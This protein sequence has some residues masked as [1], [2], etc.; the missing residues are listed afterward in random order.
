[1]LLWQV[2]THFCDIFLGYQRQHTIKSTH[3]VHATSRVS[4]GLLSDTKSI[5]RTSQVNY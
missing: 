5:R 4:T 1:M 3:P 2:L